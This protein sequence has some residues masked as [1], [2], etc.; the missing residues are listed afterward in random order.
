MSREGLTYSLFPKRETLER[1]RKIPR[2][3]CRDS[4]RLLPS[5]PLW[6]RGRQDTG[7]SAGPGA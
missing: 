2:P 1:K 5:F 7:R 6:G 3:H 4:L